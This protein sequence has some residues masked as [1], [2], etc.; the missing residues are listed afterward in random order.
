MDERLKGLSVLG[1]TGSVGTQVLD[2]V[3]TYPDR[4]TVIGLA[5]NRNHKLLSEQIEEF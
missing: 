5:A 2:I 3:R 1:S 4:F